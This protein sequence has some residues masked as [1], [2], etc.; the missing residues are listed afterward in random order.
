MKNYKKLWVR[1]PVVI[2][3]SLRHIQHHDCHQ[4]LSHRNRLIVLRG[5]STRVLGVFLDRDRG[6]N[7]RDVGGV[8]RHLLL[9]SLHQRQQTPSCVA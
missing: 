5:Q 8:L 9:D 4:Q 1:A 6:G 7:F 2:F 3:Y